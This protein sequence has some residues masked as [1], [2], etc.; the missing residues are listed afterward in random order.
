VLGRVLLDGS[1][2][3]DVDWLTDPDAIV[4]MALLFDESF[5]DAC[6]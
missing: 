1:L 3:E 2:D 5:G 6:D 4:E